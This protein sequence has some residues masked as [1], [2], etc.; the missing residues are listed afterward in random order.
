MIE[1]FL[2]DEKTIIA[3]ST[4]MDRELDVLQANA[5]ET[6]HFSNP[7]ISGENIE[8]QFDLKCTDKFANKIVYRAIC[9]IPESSKLVE[10]VKLIQM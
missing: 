7:S 8:L 4:G 9:K 2:S 1:R 10:K 6:I 5:N 3:K